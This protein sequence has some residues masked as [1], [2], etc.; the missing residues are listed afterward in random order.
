MQETLVDT[1]PTSTLLYMDANLTEMLIL[2]HY[3]LYKIS[4]CIK[5]LKEKKAGTC[6]G[7]SFLIFKASYDHLYTVSQWNYKV[8]SISTLFFSL[9]L[10]NSCY[11]AYKEYSKRHTEAQKVKQVHWNV[12]SGELAP[13][14]MWNT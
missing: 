6:L 4:V 11:K 13:K 14:S 7:Y 8:G 10:M 5:A 1:M 2:F 3:G 12:P 9:W